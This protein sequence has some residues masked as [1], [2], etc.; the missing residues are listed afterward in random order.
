MRSPRHR[1]LTIVSAG[2][3]AILALPAFAQ[4]AAAPAAP[5]P[6]AAKPK[7]PAPKILEVQ[8]LNRRDATLVELSV[9]GN[10]KGAKPI[11]LAS[12]LGSGGKMIGKIPAKA[13]CVFQING[14]FDDDSTLEVATVNLCKDRRITLTE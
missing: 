10:T 2:L 4:D 1:H 3:A 8:I 6:A 11:V 13:G 5:A 14:S 12:G 7:K 9:L